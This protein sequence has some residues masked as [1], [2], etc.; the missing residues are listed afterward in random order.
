MKKNIGRSS[1]FIFI[2]LTTLLLFIQFIFLDLKKVFF[3]QKRK[4]K[5]PSYIKSVNYTCNTTNLNFI[6]GIKFKLYIISHD[7]IS[8]EIAKKW[9]RC[10]PWTEIVRITNTNFFESII[11]KEYFPKNEKKW[12][13]FDF[14]GL[15]TYKSIKYIS[16]KKLKAS[17]ELA[18]YRPYDV[19]PL[20]LSGEQLMNQATKGHTE[21]FR[22][23]WYYMLTSMGFDLVNI[24]KLDNIEAFWRNS[25]IISPRWLKKLTKFMDD[26]INLLETNITIQKVF[27]NNAYYNEGKIIVSEKIFKKKFYYWHPFIFERLPVFF[28]NFYNA[29]IF[30][31]IQEI[32][33][34]E[35]NEN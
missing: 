25:F 5:Q 22:E 17:L 16:L 34:F 20:M 7:D 12:E 35:N 2:T 29:K 24:K 1:F 18:F 9:S 4:I 13:N 27:E 15:C 31:S 14:I 19:V 21:K 28:L 3:K 6:E 26:S 8:F 32:Q 30:S 23:V 10:M 33:N 11:Y